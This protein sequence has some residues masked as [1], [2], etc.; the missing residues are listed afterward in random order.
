M[1]TC[2]N[3]AI[4]CKVNRSW[5]GQVFIFSSLESAAFDFSLGLDFSLHNF[6]I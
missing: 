3:M 2:T 5:S 4:T 1:S 6:A